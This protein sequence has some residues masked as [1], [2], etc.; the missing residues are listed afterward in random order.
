MNGR[1][2]RLAV[3]RYEKQSR[4]GCC[5]LVSFGQADLVYCRRPVSAAVGMLCLIPDAIHAA[6]KTEPGNNVNLV[7]ELVVLGRQ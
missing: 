5:T 2:A 4:Q 3:S 7:V 6:Q 1:D